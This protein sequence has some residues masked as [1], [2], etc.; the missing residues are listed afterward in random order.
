VGTLGLTL[1]DGAA[2]QET[3]V[4]DP[5]GNQIAGAS[6]EPYSGLAGLKRDS[7]SGLLFAR[8]RM[9]DP[10]TGRFT[11]TDPLRANRPFKH[12]I[13]GG[14][15]PVSLTD[16]MGL[17]EGPPL[18]R[19][20]PYD[21]RKYICRCER[22]P[23]GFLVE[24]TGLFSLNFTRNWAIACVCGN[25]KEEIQNFGLAYGRELT[26]ALYTTFKYSNPGTIATDYVGRLS[27]G[28]T[29]EIN[30]REITPWQATWEFLGEEGGYLLFRFIGKGVQSLRSTA[31]KPLVDPSTGTKYEPLFIPSPKEKGPVIRLKMDAEG[32]LQAPQYTTAFEFQLKPQDF[33]NVDSR[34]LW[35]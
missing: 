32:N 4:K 1:D 9:L 5:F 22:N 29:I 19:V 25:T 3:S 13:Y 35:S 30:S 34:A 33:L 15:N 18:E 14:N 21:Q 10:R 7:E 12:Y 2:V 23:I 27:S 26:D 16:P 11:Q 28:R 20:N 31:M 6:V 8:N 17:Q 24:W